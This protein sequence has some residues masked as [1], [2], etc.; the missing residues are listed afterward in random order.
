MEE[1]TLGDRLREIRRWHQLSLHE[2]AGRAGLSVSGQV[3]RGAKAVAN[4]YTLE[5]VARALWVYPTE[6]GCR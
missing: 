1:T 2:A 4:L 3:E 6:L 5:A